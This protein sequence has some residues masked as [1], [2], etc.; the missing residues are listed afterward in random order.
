MIVTHFCKEAVFS[1]SCGRDSGLSERL[2][3]LS[4]SG[5]RTGWSEIRTRWKSENEP[6]LDPGLRETICLVSSI[7]LVGVVLGHVFGHGENAR[8]SIEL[9]LVRGVGRDFDLS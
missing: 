4:V 1:L 9:D 2:F 5:C 6:I 7:A 3:L 8:L